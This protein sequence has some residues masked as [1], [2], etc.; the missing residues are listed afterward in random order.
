MTRTSLVGSVDDV[1]KRK[2]LKENEVEDETD[3]CHKLENKKGRVELFMK[4]NRCQREKKQVNN[5][6]C[7]RV[8]A[9][10]RACKRVCGQSEGG[11]G[12]EEEKSE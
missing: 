11:E 4:R 1:P 12:R 5:G 3:F 9:C 6:L 2:R 7:V 10:E 8:R